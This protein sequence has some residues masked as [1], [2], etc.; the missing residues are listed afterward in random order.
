MHSLSAQHCQPHCA[1]PKMARTWSHMSSA[2]LGPRTFGTPSKPESTE[3]FETVRTIKTHQNQELHNFLNRGTHRSPEPPKPSK[4]RQLSKPGGRNLWNLEPSQDLTH[5][6]PEPV[7][8]TDLGAPEP[9]GTHRNL[10]PVRNRFPEPGSFPEPP[11]LAQ[12][13]PKSILCKD[14]IAFCCWGKTKQ[15]KKRKRTHQRPPNQNQ[16]QNQKKQNQKKQ[17]TCTHQRFWFWFGGL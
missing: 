17:R 8:G 12:S 3:T 10:E 6:K 4:P 9:V 2:A 16:N 5:R 7:P 1:N 13:T 11:Q 15:T 14:P